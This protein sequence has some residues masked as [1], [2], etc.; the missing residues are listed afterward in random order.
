[1]GK[2]LDRRQR[3]VAG[4]AFDRVHGAHDLRLARG[5][6]TR[7]VKRD[8]YRFGG[9]QVFRGFSHELVQEPPPQGVAAGTGVHGLHV[10]RRCRPAAA[11][12]PP[13]APVPSA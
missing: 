8:Q 3:E 7:G 5:V 2:L 9:I 12:E 13:A 4:G 6:E 11:H 1:M 10:A